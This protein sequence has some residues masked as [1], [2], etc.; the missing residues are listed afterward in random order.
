MKDLKKQKSYI[1]T[2]YRYRGLTSSEEKNLFK[3][4]FTFQ[5]PYNL[6]QILK[7]YSIHWNQS[8][9]FHVMNEALWAAS[10]VLPLCANKEE[11]LFMLKVFSS[12]LLQVD[13]WAHSDNLSSLLATLLDTALQSKNKT[14]IDQHMKVRLKWNK[15]LNPWL[16]RQSIV[17]LLNYSRLRKKTLSFEELIYFVDPLCADE[18]FYVQRAV[19]WTLREI[20]NF[21][22]EKTYMYLTKNIHKITSLA[23][24]AATEKLKKEEKEKLL[25]LRKNFRKAT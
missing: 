18:A 23:F 10:R 14:L 7:H 19:G 4:N 12:W 5:K 1:G 21:Y 25:F 22:P 11:H 13:N 8:K 9:D 15:S 17:S 6:R 3:K 24:S 2:Y 16:R 20:Y